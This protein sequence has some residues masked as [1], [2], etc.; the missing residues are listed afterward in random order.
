MASRIRYLGLFHVVVVSQ[1]RRVTTSGVSL[2]RRRRAMM[3]RL[4]PIFETPFVMCMPVLIRLSTIDR[5]SG[6]RCR[7][8]L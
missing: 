8:Y 1:I 7:V 4:T 2:T 5:I 3:M 6:C